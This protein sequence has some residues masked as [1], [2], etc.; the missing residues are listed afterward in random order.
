MPNISF[1][2]I[3]YNSNNNILYNLP[4]KRDKIFEDLISLR[5]LI[6]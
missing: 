5:P 6:F 4:K 3:T 1:K 2:A